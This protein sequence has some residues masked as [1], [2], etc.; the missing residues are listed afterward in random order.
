M[1][2]SSDP[3]M[4]PLRKQPEA[5]QSLL[6]SADPNDRRSNG[7]NGLR[8]IEYGIYGRQWHA[9]AALLS[10]FYKDL[11]G[12]NSYGQTPLDV[13]IY[14]GNW[15]I[16]QALLQ[17]GACPD[18]SVAEP[19][20][21]IALYCGELGV[22]ST[23]SCLGADTNYTDGFNMSLLERALLGLYTEPQHTDSED[24]RLT[25]EE[26]CE[27]QRRIVSVLLSG[28]ADPLGL[29]EDGLNMLE[30]VYDRLEN[31]TE[32]F[33]IDERLIDLLDVCIWE[34][35]EMKL[36]MSR[37]TRKRKRE[38]LEHPMNGKF[39]RCTRVRRVI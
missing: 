15:S 35:E 32:G 1:T 36:R 21:V 38:V 13:A 39:I 7:V 20:L 23:L 10:A 2:G 4:C 6:H 19:S 8:P 27:Y 26:I 29:N 12:M 14:D 31:D 18:T 25:V 11:D 17:A 33:V 22:V 5:I 16:V 30:L 9:M 3:L 34:H 24:R 37:E 28:G